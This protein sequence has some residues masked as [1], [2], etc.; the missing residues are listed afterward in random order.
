MTQTLLGFDFGLKHIGV[1][2]GQTLTRTT[3][4]LTS[5]K[6]HGGIPHWP[7]IDQLIKTWQ[8]QAIVVGIPCHMDGKEHHITH[9]ARGFANALAQHY[10][11][12]IHRMDERLSSAE[13][14]AQ[15]FD[16]GGYRA[17]SKQAI[18]QRSAQLILQ[19]WL[20]TQFNASQK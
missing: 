12:T 11:I 3:R 13:A 15:L 7:D 9:A 10:P 8:P 5:L 18:D 14:R 20:E 4:G 16:Q 19:S 1:A 17:L 6:A 2:V